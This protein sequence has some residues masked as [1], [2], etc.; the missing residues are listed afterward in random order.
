MHNHIMYI[1]IYMY[2]CRIHELYIYIYV[3]CCYMYIWFVYDSMHLYHLWCYRFCMG[4]SSLLNVSKRENKEPSTT[5]T[6]MNDWSQPLFSGFSLCYSLVF[7]FP[8]LN[9][10]LE[11]LIVKIIHQ[12]T[13]NNTNHH[14]PSVFLSISWS[15]EY[16]T[17]FP[18]D[19]PRHARAEG[20]E[21]AR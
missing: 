12:L 6:N 16:P 19:L 17:L 11:N 1:Y 8:C 14:P 7:T 2:K 3:I 15:T 18:F 21:G 10:H 20:M 9:I 4:V 5:S 13:K